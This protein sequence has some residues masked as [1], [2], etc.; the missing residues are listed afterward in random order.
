[1]EK[2]TNNTEKKESSATFIGHKLIGQKNERL[3][4][5]GDHQFNMNHQETQLQLEGLDWCDAFVL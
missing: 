5:K 4:A 2:Q 3:V 1:M